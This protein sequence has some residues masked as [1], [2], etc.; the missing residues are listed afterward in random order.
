[1]EVG[2]AWEQ[3]PVSGD[4]VVVSISGIEES[5]SVGSHPAGSTELQSLKTRVPISEP[6]SSS[7]SPER[8][9]FSTPPN[10]PPKTPE[11]AVTR[12]RTLTRSAYSK[13]KSRFAEPH[14]SYSDESH[15]VEESSHLVHSGSPYRNSPH[16]GSP[17]S[18]TNVRTAPVTPKT[19]LMASPGEE[20]EED[21]EDVYKTENIRIGDKSGNKM[22]VMAIIE[23]IVFV[24]IM[25][26]LVASLTVEKL[27]KRTIWSLEIW[28]WCVLVVVI[29]CGGLITKWFMNVLVF[30]IER[31]FLLKKKVLYFVYGL[32]KSVRVFIWLCLIL[33]AWGLLISRGVRRPRKTTRILNYITRAIA[34]TLIGAGMWMMKTLFVKILASSF[35]VNRFFD[36]IQESIFH[37]FVLRTLSGP[38]IASM[39]YEARLSNGRNSGELS[40]KNLK[41]GKQVDKEEVIDVEKL[42]KMKQEKISAWTM[43]GLIQVIQGS[44]LHTISNAL[45]ESVDDGGVEQKD[46]EIT[47][48]WEA[49]AAAYRIFKNVARHGHKYIEE[50]DLLRFMKKEDVDNV[51]PMFEG[52]TET[53]KIKKSSLRKW[54]VNVYNERKSL[55]HSLNDTKT[56]I[57]ELNRILSGVI[58]VVIFIVWYI[59]MGFA[60]TQVLVFIS[61]QLLLVAFIFGNTCKT[62]FEAIIFV[63]VMH[64]FDVGDRCVID[65]VQM[66]VEEMNILTT[67]F[68]RYD[69]E[70]I[71][72]PN[73]VLATKPISNFYRSPEMS[74]RVEFAIGLS[75]SAESIV[76]LKAKIKAYLESKPQ[77]WRPNH[78]VQVKDIEEVNKMKMALFVNHTMNFQNYPEKTSRRTELMYEL[79]KIFE[80]LDI[81]YN[82]LPQEVHLIN[83]GS[84]AQACTN[85]SR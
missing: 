53:R 82:L 28:K 47:S 9:H 40:F 50:E 5:R 46:K 25:S 71:S 67:I 64:P 79:K 44:G 75:T 59:L 56:A 68:L 3:K 58:L 13:P 37:Q 17:T 2:K 24:C 23:W 72:Y 36:R 32:K 11:E 45:D 8:T 19:P 66:V 85:A 74:D 83:T 26:V 35:H 30:L 77:H 84:A 22:K 39:E 76:A 14:S 1:M 65:G 70:K 55:A 73:S 38:P 20:E 31:N 81:K 48:E 63:F 62:V 51:F 34:S 41:K 6:K 80:E 43:K 21:D 29:F 60:T 52:A 4:E 7:S 18:K 16:M 33:L 27:Q 69:N 57:E 54:V 49:K 15:L 78:S 61:S 10:R 12:R 42:H